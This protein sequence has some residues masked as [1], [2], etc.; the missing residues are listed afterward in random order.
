MYRPLGF[1]LILVFATVVGCG[2]DVPKF[3]NIK[4]TVTFNGKPIEKGTIMFA[5]QGRPPST[6]QIDDGKFNGQA[7]VGEN[8]VSVYAAKR[9][10]NAPKISPQ[11]EMYMKGYREKFKNL[12]GQEGGGS[13]DAADYDPNM[14]DYIPPEWGFAASKQT[15]M[16]ESGFTNEFEFNIKG[17]DKN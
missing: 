6:M 5:V 10:A 8:K 15:R 11:A 3:A 17:P 12:P 16:V 2:S 13:G 7:M 1:F 14:V 4:G 9:V